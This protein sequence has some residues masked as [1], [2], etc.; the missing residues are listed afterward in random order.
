MLTRAYSL[1][2]PCSLQF[3]S[4]QLLC[5]GQHWHGRQTH[6]DFFQ[7]IA[8]FVQ[9][10]RIYQQKKV[11]KFGMYWHWH[12]IWKNNGNQPWLLRFMIIHLH[13]WPPAGRYDTASDRVC[14]SAWKSLCETRRWRPM[15]HG[16]VATHSGLGRDVCGKMGE[17]GPKNRNMLGIFL[18]KIL[19]SWQKNTQVIQVLSSIDP[20]S[21][22]RQSFWHVIWT[23]I[24]HIFWHSTLHSVWHIIWHF[25]WHSI[26]R[27]IW[28][29]FWIF[30]AYNI[31]TFIL[32]C[33]L[34]SILHSIWSLYWHSIWHL[35]RY[36]FW[37][38]ICDLVHLELEVKEE[39]HLFKI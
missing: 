8:C 21:D 39:L 17:K 4:T 29:T 33:Y 2:H 10:M 3:H 28:H 36:L 13:Q 14:S 32:A 22:F 23:Y 5:R 6:L 37:H 30:L 18:G 38:S 20:H 34:A 35:F 31:L 7:V 16:L 9:N 19:G 26:W 15:E 24:W 25:L 12:S 11:L 1:P 27:L